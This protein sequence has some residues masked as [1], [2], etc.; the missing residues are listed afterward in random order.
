MKD[1]LVNHLVCFNDNLNGEHRHI[2]ENIKKQIDF[3]M[4]FVDKTKTNVIFDVGCLNGA[5]SILLNHYLPDSQI[6][7][8]EVSLIPFRLS[9]DNVSGISNIK[10]NLFAL[11]N[12]DGATY[13][14]LYRNPG[15]N[16]LLEKI[17]DDEK[18]YDARIMRDLIPVVRAE[19]FCKSNG[20]Y[21]VD[22][23]KIDVQGFELEVFK[24]FGEMLSDVSVIQTECAW[25]LTYSNQP[26]YKD[27]CDYLSQFGFVEKAKQIDYIDGCDECDVIFVNERI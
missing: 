9:V 11:G 18:S 20:I 8:F 19:T 27:I 5:E 7:L 14:N 10:P 25:K 21:K 12:F 22:L 15:L 17:V 13:L 4:T 1:N 2:T 3:L 6:F 23:I 24:G 26:S 16:S